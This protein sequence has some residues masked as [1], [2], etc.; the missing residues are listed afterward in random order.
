MYVEWQ[1]Q[2]DTHCE[3]EMGSGGE[4]VRISS[5]SDR[6]GKGLKQESQSFH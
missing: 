6:E 2:K 5:W 3:V 1:S 4:Q